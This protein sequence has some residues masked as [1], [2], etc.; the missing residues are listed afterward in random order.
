MRGL[1]FDGPGEIRFADDIAEPT[2]GHPA[3]AIVEVTLAGLCGS[4]LH[5]YEGR[6]ACATGIIPG[7]EAVGVVTETGAHVSTVQAGDRVIVAFT[8]SCGRCD[9]CASGLSSR[10]RSGRLFG[11]GDPT[12]AQPLLHGGQAERLCVPL[13]DATLVPIPDG[14]DDDTAL[15]LTDN[16]PTAW[17]AVARTD[18]TE[19][20][21][22]VIGLGAVGLCAVAAAR[23][24][25]VTEILA[26]DPIESRRRAAIQLGV[27]TAIPDEATGSFPTVVEAAGPPAAQRLAAALADVGGT[28][29]IIAV[30]TADVFGIDPVTAYEKNL[31]IR[32]GRAPVRSVLDAVLPH[33]SVGSLTVPTSSVITHPNRPLT[34]GPGLYRAFAA[35]HAGMIKATI[36]P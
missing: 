6:E 31:T 3:D 35:R 11:W 20:P 30:Q 24:L 22:A 25:G 26:I 10:C 16:F 27:S 28:I 13:A 2:I 17:H 1:I 21:L 18:W 9:R 12:G 19:G 33:I 32:S 8:T 34:D 36:R 5:P 23:S 4:D 7:H 29:S 14:V 15:L